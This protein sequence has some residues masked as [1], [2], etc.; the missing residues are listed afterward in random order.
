MG[1]GTKA[2]FVFDDAVYDAFRSVCEA[3][4]RSMTWVLTQAMAEWV[5][6]YRSE[7][8][9]ALPEVVEAEK[10]KKGLGGRS[11]GSN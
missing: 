10:S 2:T 11:K 6:K 9:G 8:G 7:H 5:R 4:G 3:E 1:N